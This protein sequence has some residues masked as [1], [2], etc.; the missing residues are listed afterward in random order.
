MKIIL[1]AARSISVPLSS[2]SQEREW[3]RCV[4]FGPSG[5]PAAVAGLGVGGKAA[6]TKMPKSRVGFV[7]GRVPQG[8]WRGQGPAFLVQT[9]SLNHSI[10]KDLLNTYYVP[11]LD[12]NKISVLKN[13][14]LYWER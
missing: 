10:S 9:D 2:E 1:M 11:D 14:I 13:L 6:G 5:R 7:Q 4:F 3:D 12:E 8:T